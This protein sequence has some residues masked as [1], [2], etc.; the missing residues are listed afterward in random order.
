MR[1]SSSAQARKILDARM[2]RIY[3]R[4]VQA[5]ALAD[6]M[7]ATEETILRG[8]HLAL[9]KITWCLTHAGEIVIASAKGRHL[10]EVKRN[11]GKHTENHGEH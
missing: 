8:A 5:R 4:A 7:T 3:Q 11:S 1:S 9:Q 6:G 2:E 10:D